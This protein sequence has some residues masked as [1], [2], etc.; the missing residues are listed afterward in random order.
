MSHN[1]T[2]HNV[3]HMG[4]S[5]IARTAV[6]GIIITFLEQNKPGCLL[7][8]NSDHVYC[9]RRPL[10]FNFVIFD[11][12]MGVCVSHILEKSK[13]VWMGGGGRWGLVFTIH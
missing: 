1:P 11:S 10:L 5:V 6:K 13:R 12:L 2:D 7:G 8:E 3:S 4:F 9:L